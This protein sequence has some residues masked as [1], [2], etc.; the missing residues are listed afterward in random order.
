[1]NFVKKNEH[2]N[3]DKMQRANERRWEIKVVINFHME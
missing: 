2:N 3:Y 1:M